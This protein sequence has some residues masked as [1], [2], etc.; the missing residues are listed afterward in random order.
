MVLS[1]GCDMDAIGAAA[2]RHGYVLA[3][4]VRRYAWLG[5]HV[6]HEVRRSA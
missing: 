6:V 1:E 4:A 2:A 5:L 3:D